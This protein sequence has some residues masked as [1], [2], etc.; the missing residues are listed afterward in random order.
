MEGLVDTV[1]MTFHHLPAGRE[2][3]GAEAGTWAEVR[4]RGRTPSL[5]HSLRGHPDARQLDLGCLFARCPLGRH[6]GP[7]RVVP[8]SRFDCFK[9]LRLAHHH[10][11]FFHHFL[12]RPIY[13]SIRMLL[14]GSTFY[15]F[16]APAEHRRLFGWTRRGMLH[17]LNCCTWGNRVHRA[18]WDIRVADLYA[19]RH[20]CPGWSSP[21]TSICRRG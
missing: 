21:V 2:Y 10:L 19:G 7:K 9:R 14:L 13:L 6:G 20:R 16:S 18:Q 4:R 17:D 1:I 8:V 3:A 15:T 11:P 12:H 5:Y